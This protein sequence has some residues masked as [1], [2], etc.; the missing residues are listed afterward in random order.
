[1]FS[2]DQL[3][4]INQLIVNQSEKIVILTHHNP[5]G[6]AIGSSLALYLYLKSKNIDS[7]VIVPNEFPKF[8][9]WM[10]EVKKIVIAELRKKHTEILIKNA[11][12]IF[13]LD[14]NATNRIE[15]LKEYLIQS[16]AT[17]ILIDHHQQPENF[18][19]VYSDTSQPATCQMIYKF[20]NAMNDNHLIDK[21]I[22]TCLY[23][24][25][26]TD[27]G[28]FRFRNTTGETHRIVAD[29]LEKGAIPDEISSNILDSNSVSRLKLL[30]ILLEKMLYFPE[31]KSVILHLTKDELLQFGYQKGDT[32]GFVNYGLSIKGVKFSALILDD[33]YNDYRRISLRSKGIFDVNN[34]ARIHFN[35]GGHTNAAGGKSF[36]TMEVTLKRM[37]IL[38]KNE[39][40]LQ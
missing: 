20:I 10:P 1:M 21:N 3:Q 19:F 34:F 16:K 38:I 29:L 12:V 22:A 13:C 5:D 6:D 15:T 7:T 18:D 36:E 30:G 9:K 17:K 26:L 33:L 2:Q 14:F 27:T 23:S 39:K 11:T 32:E 31:N 40:E 28:S 8:L 37:E 24:G 4:E 35:G 25:L